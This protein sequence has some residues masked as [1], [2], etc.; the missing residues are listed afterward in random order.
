M[1]LES[2]ELRIADALAASLRA[3]T[4]A[5][6]LSCAAA[7]RRFVPDT[8]VLKANT[9]EVSVVPG[10]VEVSNLTH[11]SDLFAV[12]IH[13][14][15]ARKFGSDADVVDL[16]ELRTQ[17]VDAIR[18]DNL[19]IASPAMPDGVSWM[20]VENNVTYDRDSIVNGRVFLCDIGVSYRI[21]QGK[22]Q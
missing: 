17:I 10:V 15:L 1:S 21:S 13:V 14:V 4:F 12:E 16:I 11:G 8:T 9:L 7:T 20:N 2:I 18:S 19:P 22:Q 5:G 3:A 6:P